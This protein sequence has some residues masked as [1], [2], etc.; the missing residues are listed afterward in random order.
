M[1]SH[2]YHDIKIGL[3][4]RDMLNDLSEMKSDLVSDIEFTKLIDKLIM[5][6]KISPTLYY[7]K[8]LIFDTFLNILTYQNISNLTKDYIV[9]YMT[10][11]TLSL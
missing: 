3:A 9:N 1:E 5:C 6:V 7:S 11:M 2:Y 8:E 4:E 10:K